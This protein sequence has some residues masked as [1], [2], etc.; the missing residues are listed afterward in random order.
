[1]FGVPEYQAFDNYPETEG[2]YVKHL[3]P[4]YGLLDYGYRVYIGTVSQPETIA[5]NEMQDLIDR[6]WITLSTFFKRVIQYIH[7]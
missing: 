2:D 6:L 7:A 4:D 1:V 5:E 3:A